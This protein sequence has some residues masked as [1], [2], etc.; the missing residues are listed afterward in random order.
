M[1]EQSQVTLNLTELTKLDQ[2]SITLDLTEMS[3]LDQD[4]KEGQE[5]L[6]DSLPSFD[7]QQT[8]SLSQL[9]EVIQQEILQENFFN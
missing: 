3:K 5:Q 8:L 6:N 9:L 1:S 2:E 4:P 7:S